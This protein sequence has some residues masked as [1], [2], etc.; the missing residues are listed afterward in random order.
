VSVLAFLLGL[1]LAVWS[2][3]AVYLIID[4]PE[5]AGAIRTICLRIA[6][7]IIF[8]ALFGSV[9]HAP[10]LWAFA[11]VAIAHLTTSWLARWLIGKRGFNSK[12]TQ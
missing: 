7:I 12:S 1:P 3:A 5:L 2:L 11:L 10:L 6:A 4:G 8:I 9:S